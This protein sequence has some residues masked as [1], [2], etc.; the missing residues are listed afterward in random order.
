MEPTGPN[1]TQRVATC[2]SVF[3]A[4]FPT[5]G[6][7]DYTEGIYD[8]D[9][10]TPYEVAKQR[11]LDYLLDEIRCGPG[12]RVLEIGCGNGRL[13]EAIRERGGIGVGI[14][15]TPE[16]VT[17]CRQK[18]LDAR[19]ED[20]LQL[21]HSWDTQFDAIVANGP[22]EH[23][24]QVT[25]AAS[26]RGDTIYRHMFATMH[27][28][29]DPDSPVRRVVNTT[30]HFNRAPDARRLLRSPLAYRPFSD[31][32]HYSMLIHSFGGF[33]P[34][35]GQLESCADG[36]FDLIHQVDGTRDYFYTSEEW[37][38]RVRRALVSPSAARILARSLPRVFREPLQYFTMF[39]CMLITRSW[40]WQFRTDSPPAKLWRQTWQW[41]PEGP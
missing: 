6:L 3:D 39:T 38:R 20:F 19:L 31:D 13:L 2:Y 15:V 41:L 30:V 12:T 40:N 23:F 11:Q 28:L 9:P 7:L 8:D 32:F 21:D 16:Q 26:G 36:R 34:I 5:I 29:I 14:T 22:I 17:H 27:R 24:V 1:A 37:L 35:D 33:Y 10:S 4:F 25:D 18:G